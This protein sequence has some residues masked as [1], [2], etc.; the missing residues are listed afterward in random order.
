MTDAMRSLPW[1]DAHLDLACLAVNGR[2]LS[3]PL[4]RCGGPWPPPAVSLPS[5]RAGRVHAC[6]A[7]IF[8][9]ADGA[10]PEGYPAGDA[11]RAHTV[12]RAQLEVYLTLRDRG[13]LAI[14]LP[15]AL[16]QDPG[17]GEIRGGMGVAEVVSPT[18]AQQ[19]T[20]LGRDHRLHIGIL[21]EGADIVRA[22]DE[23]AWWAQR[24]CCA[25]GMAWWKPSRYAGGNGTT[26]GLTD[27]GRALAKEIDA[28]GLVHDLSHLSDN[29]ADELLTLTGAAVIASHSNC[30]A[31]LG[32]DKQGNPNQRHL[33]DRHIAEIARRG[34]VIGLNLFNQF[35]RDGGGATIDDCARHIEH[36]CEVA[37]SRR[38]IGL[39]SDMDG[40]LTAEQL[41]EGIRSPSDLPALLGALA[42]R[43][44][45]A[46]D[47]EGFACGNWARFWRDRP[48]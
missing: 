47:L 38:H 15:G 21:I 42:Q 39:G 46:E 36:V 25:V 13:L 18:P 11:E 4:D 48:R 33:Q 17:V 29:A 31:L 43:G 24:G 32:P 35:L 28:A 8:T 12:G 26:T 40:G 41:P 7:T 19:L 27:L 2:D 16:R 10:G 30:R 5:L 14:D 45:S 9:E 1:F 3:A 37:G 23:L 6:L 22:P 44:W 20:T 34:G